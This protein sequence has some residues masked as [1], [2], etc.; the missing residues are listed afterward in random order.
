MSVLVA[1][2]SF[3]PLIF[4]LSAQA[5]TALGGPDSAL[6][7]IEVANTPTTGNS[8]GLNIEW[9]LFFSGLL[10]FF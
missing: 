2:T 3:F 4:R 8:L 9:V 6:G 10:P 1:A 7:G 5:S